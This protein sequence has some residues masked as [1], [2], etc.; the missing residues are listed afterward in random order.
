MPPLHTSLP[1][2]QS[3]SENKNILFPQ[4][5]YSFFDKLE[6]C[7]LLLRRAHAGWRRRQIMAF[8]H[9]GRHDTSKVQES[10]SFRAVAANIVVGSLTPDST[11]SSVQE[12]TPKSCMTSLREHNLPPRTPFADITNTVERSVV[13]TTKVKGKVRERK[14]IFENSNSIGKEN[15]KGSTLQSIEAHRTKG[16]VKDKVRT[17]NLESNNFAEK[18]KGK[19]SNWE[20]APLK[21]WIRNLFAEEFST[22]KSTD[23]VLYDEDLEETRFD[24]SYFSEDSDSDMDSADGEH[25]KFQTVISNLNIYPFCS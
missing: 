4:S 14:T 7:I 23:S 11:P 22:N 12:S 19:V 6:D 3:L 1:R 13:H 17:T 18:G 5:F 25:C 8:V 24:A 2:A 10:E 21:D 9:F 16:G 15:A 20:N